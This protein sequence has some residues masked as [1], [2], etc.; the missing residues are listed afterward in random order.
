MEAIHEPVVAASPVQEL[1]LQ[2]HRM[3]LVRLVAVRV[4]FR[5]ISTLNIGVIVLANTFSIF[6]F[7]ATMGLGCL[8]TALWYSEQR[9]LYRNIRRLEERLA[10]RSGSEWEDLYI[11]TR[12]E[13]STFRA[14]EAEPTL[15]L[16]LSLFLIV[17]RFSM[18]RYFGILN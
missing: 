9:S 15:W 10:E 13:P 6:R 2:K 7:T 11:R 5:W 8:L 12:Y 16:A 1:L 4:S 14:L 18:F 17:V 3:F